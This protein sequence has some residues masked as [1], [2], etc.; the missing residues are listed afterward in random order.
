MTRGAPVRR[1][2]LIRARPSVTGLSRRVLGVGVGLDW[3]A[4]TDHPGW[5]TSS[6]G[7]KGGRWWPRSPLAVLKASTPPLPDH[8][9]SFGTGSRAGSGRPESRSAAHGPPTCGSRWRR[10]DDASI[11]AITAHQHHRM[12]I[13]RPNV[14]VALRHPGLP[15]TSSGCRPARAPHTKGKTHERSSHHLDTHRTRRRPMTKTPRRI[16][17]L[18]VA[19]MTALLLGAGLASTAAAAPPSQQAVPVPITGTVAGTEQQLF[20]GTLNV[21]RFATQNGELT[22]VGTLVGTLTDPVTGAQSPIDTAVSAPV[23]VA[24]SS[25]QI[26]DLVLGPLDLDLLGLQV[27]LDTVHL[28]ITAQSGPGNLLGNLLCA[29]TH[30]LDGPASL[31]AIVALLNRLLGIL[32]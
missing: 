5:G 14:M 26:L 15:A 7:P 6:S 23:A 25:C 19:V 8:G 30:L 17:V 3:S 11:P 18:F 28:N 13:K 20:S 9:K 21:Q 4:A 10:I 1:W 27:H 29:V 2:E 32:G 24:Q 31:N 12:R 22:A 16:G